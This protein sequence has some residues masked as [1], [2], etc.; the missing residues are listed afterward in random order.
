MLLLVV[1]GVFTAIIL[2]RYGVCSQKAYT[3]QLGEKLSY[4]IIKI[5]ISGCE[6]K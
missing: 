6:P 4:L 3:E 5:V 2:F 1:L